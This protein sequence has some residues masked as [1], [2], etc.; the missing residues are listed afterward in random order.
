MNEVR[1]TGKVLNCYIDDRTQN[2]VAKLAVSYNHTIGRH[3][4][5]YESII[6]VIMADE[7][8]IPHLDVRQRDTVLVEGYLHLEEKISQK[9]N[10]HKTLRVYATN[11][12]VTKS[13]AGFDMIDYTRKVL[14]I[15]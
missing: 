14:G 12:E 6:P 1:L 3:T 9:G 15:N 2:F 5:G 8:K 7:H 13:K 10:S 4:I 11:I